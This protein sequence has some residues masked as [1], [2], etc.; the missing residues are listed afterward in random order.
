MFVGGTNGF[1][2]YK[3]PLAA[4]GSIANT[5]SGAP[6][7]YASSLDALAVGDSTIFLPAGSSIRAIKDDVYDATNRVAGTY[8]GVRGLSRSGEYIYWTEYADGI[9]FPNAATKIGRAH[10]ECDGTLGP[11]EAFATGYAPFDVAASHKTGFV[12]VLHAAE[13][14]PTKLGWIDVVDLS[15]CKD[16]FSTCAPT[17]KLTSDD[18]AG[19][20]DPSGI[21][22]SPDDST[23]FVSN[24]NGKGGA[25]LVLSLANPK[26]PTLLQTFEAEKEYDGVK[27]SGDIWAWHMDFFDGYLYVPMEFGKGIAVF[28][29]KK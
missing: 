15:T 6:A 7:S 23:L 19:L 21:R 24:F 27:L 4:D 8:G 22:I 5:D 10:F 14:L 18:I 17:K 29:S 2:F 26:A 20:A 28:K 16:D 13:S 1:Q 3:I 12:Y 9:A 25:V 11:R